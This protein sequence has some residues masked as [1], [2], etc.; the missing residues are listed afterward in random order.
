MIQFILPNGMEIKCETI[1]EAKLVAKEFAG[2]ID[3]IMMVPPRGPGVG[4]PKKAVRI[5]KNSRSTGSGPEE[6]WARS[7]WY[8]LRAG[9][10]TRNTA[11]TYLATMKKTDPQEYYAL[12]K[13]F[14]AWEEEL[15]KWYSGQKKITLEAAISELRKIGRHQKEEF[16]EILEEFHKRKKK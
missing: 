10:M 7:L 12:E 3:D 5:G 9:D 2:N 8:S 14:R 16:E 15:G 1:E 4:R 11:R 13:E 6:S